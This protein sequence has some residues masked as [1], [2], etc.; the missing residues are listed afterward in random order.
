[1]EGVRHRDPAP[2]PAGTQ[3]PAP[4]TGCR[5]DLCAK[6]KMISL[7]FQP[8]HGESPAHVRGTYFRICRDGTLRGPDNAI[9]ARYQD[10]LWQL[11]HRQHRLFECTGPVY[12]RVTRKDGRQEHVG[13]CGPI[14]ASGGAVFAE[15][16]CLCVHAPGAGICH[17]LEECQEVALLG[18]PRA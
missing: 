8:M 13:P 16:A 1:V 10:G 7:V 5:L 2:F 11:A 6:R 4:S 15:N 3:I 17:S 14:K 12:V 18:A 9:V